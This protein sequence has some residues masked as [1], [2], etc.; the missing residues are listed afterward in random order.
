MLIM[1]QHIKLH[2]SAIDIFKQLELYDTRFFN[3]CLIANQD[4]GIGKDK[5]CPVDIAYYAEQCKISKREAMSKAMDIVLKLQELVIEIDLDNGRILM[6]NLIHKFTCIEAAYILSVNWDKDLLPFI[7]NTMPS[8]K[9]LMVNPAMG[10]VKSNKRYCM[11]LLI[12]KSLWKLDKEESFFLQKLAIRN[13]LG[14]KDTEYMEFKQ[15]NAKIIQPTL[16]D[17]QKIL[18]INLKTK[19]RGSSVEFSYA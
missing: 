18:R 10:E 12:E 15:L 8:G 1:T 11:Y 4:M 17:M 6:T 9:F 13:I 16:K 14:L 2:H 3:S 5:Y 7:G 19:V